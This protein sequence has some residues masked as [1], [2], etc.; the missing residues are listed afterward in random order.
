MLTDHEIRSVVGWDWT[1]I[2]P[3]GMTSRHYRSKCKAV[4]RTL[5]SV[6]RDD[7]V[8][9]QFQML[10]VP[11]YAA[12]AYK[13]AVT[14]GYLHT[15]KALPMINAL[16]RS[17]LLNLILEHDRLAMYQYY[18]MHRSLLAMNG[19][20]GPISSCVEKLLERCLLYNCPKILHHVLAKY[21]VE[22][23]QIARLGLLQ[24]AKRSNYEASLQV[25]R[26][27]STE[28]VR[29]DPSLLVN[30]YQTI[31]WCETH[32]QHADLSTTLLD[33]LRILVGTIPI[34]EEQAEALQRQVQ[35][36]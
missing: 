13:Y 23:P 36:T 35:T 28:C 21:Q 2:L 9:Y 22:F 29:R 26:Q 32:L 30:M 14:H 6:E 17:C 19:D 20:V 3:L 16:E 18:N 8:H 34:S 4:F 27:W 1:I 11:N 33:E 5:T 31:R 12:L 25:L 10:T 24:T 7:L 15:L